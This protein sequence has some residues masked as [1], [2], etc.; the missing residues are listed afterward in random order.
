MKLQ[1]ASG[2]WHQILDEPGTYLESSATAMFICAFS[3]GLRNGWYDV[4]VLDEVRS[5]S[6]VPGRACASRRL[7]GTATC[8]ACA[9]DQ[10]SP[11]PAP[12]IAR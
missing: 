6:S 9:A 8:T 7:T 5:A 1:D 12:I 3:R 10:V 4:A 2:L 11:S